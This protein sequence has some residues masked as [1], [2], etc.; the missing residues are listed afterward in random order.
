VRDKD[1]YAGWK[2]R[3]DRLS[4]GELEVTLLNIKRDA[5]NYLKIVNPDR[6]SSQEVRYRLKSYTRL[7]IMTPT[8]F[9]LNAMRWR[10]DG[11]IDDLGLCKIV[12]LIQSFLVRRIFSYVPTNTL[13]RIFIRLTEQLPDYEDLVHATHEA[14]SQ[15]GLRWPADSQFREHFMTYK[16][17]QDTRPSQRSLVLRTLELHLGHKEAPS[18]EQLDIEHV[19][20]QTL[21]E[22]WKADLGKDAEDLHTR[23]LHTIGHLTLTGY[24]SELSNDTFAVKRERYRQSNV[25]SEPQKANRSQSQLF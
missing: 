17:Y 23:W 12:D 11:K 16:L 25:R 5:D 8:P 19:M 9:L 13:N 2:K 21:T 3:C 20:P 15:A 7:G 1:I 4:Q 22:E 10:E 24:N 18:L 6:E 14:L